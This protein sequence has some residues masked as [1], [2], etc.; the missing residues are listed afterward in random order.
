[1]ALRAAL[2]GS[3]RSPSATPRPV[4]QTAVTL[5][6]RNR[7]E[8]VLIPPVTVG[9]RYHL[10]DSRLVAGVAD[11][12]SGMSTPRL[13]VLQEHGTVCLRRRAVGSSAESF[14]GRMRTTASDT[15]PL[16]QLSRGL[17]NKI[18]ATKPG[19]S[20]HPAK[21]PYS[22]LSES[23]GQRTHRGGGALYLGPLPD[24]I[25]CNG[26]PPTFTKTARR[27]SP[28]AGRLIAW[29]TLQQE[30]LSRRDR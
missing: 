29:D 10:H 4:C 5:L 6:V 30:F 14:C 25:H 11:D 15:A 26:D 17:Q 12:E 16:E 23:S 13:N 1:M 18:I 7:S 27:D 28:E 9:G 20:E 22:I 24:A 8:V 21:I 3:Q 19:A 2:C